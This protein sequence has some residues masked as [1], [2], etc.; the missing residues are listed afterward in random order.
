MSAIYEANNFLSRK[1]WIPT[2]RK[3]MKEK[4]RHPVPVKWLF[5]SKE[6]HGGLIRLKSRNLVKGY[7]Q[8]PRVDFTKSLSKV[9]PDTSTR[10]LIGLNLYHEEEVWVAELCEVEAAFLH[11]NMEVEM[12]IEWNEGIVG[13]GI[14]TK[15]FLE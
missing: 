2:K 5:Q 9:V 7:I 6:E 15:E 14:I 3:V 1:A 10:V 4:S 8:V 12:F 13:L 11:P